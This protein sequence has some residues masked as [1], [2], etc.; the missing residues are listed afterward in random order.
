MSIWY[1]NRRG[2]RPP[3]SLASLTGRELRRGF[4]KGVFFG[5]RGQAGYGPEA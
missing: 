1:S 2:R 5:E 3:K 4:E